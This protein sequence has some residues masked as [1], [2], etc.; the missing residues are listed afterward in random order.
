M[1]AVPVAVPNGASTGP[2]AERGKLFDV[3]RI[4]IVID[5]AD[6]TVVKL[7]F[8]GSVDLDRGNAKQV[9][10]YNDLRA[11]RQTEVVVT[12]HVAGATM[13]HRR[14]S[15]G[16]VDAIR[17]NEIS[18][19]GS[20]PTSSGPRSSGARKP[21]RF[22]PSL[23]PCNH[24][25]AGAVPA[26]AGTHTRRERRCPMDAKEQLVMTP[27]NERVDDGVE[28]PP[29]GSTATSRATSNRQ[30]VED[31]EYELVVAHGRRERA[32]RGRIAKMRR[33]LVRRRCTQVPGPEAWAEQDDPEEAAGIYSKLAGHLWRL[34]SPEADGRVQ[35]RLNG[36]VGLVLDHTKRPRQDRGGL[37]HQGPPVPPRRLHRS[38]ENPDRE[39]G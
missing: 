6:P 20:R 5:E 10:F 26:H 17:T 18:S 28:V 1:S 9:E 27:L 19:R 37:R 2:D 12:I 34:V 3:P 22:L 30:A 24:D 32:D 16:D 21:S 38:A 29:N 4:G 31:K 13:R 23:S 8:S 36:D 35:A 15:E 39:G 33:S 11:G 25:P 7:A 14:D